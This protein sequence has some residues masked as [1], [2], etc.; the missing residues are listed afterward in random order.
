MLEL[1]RHLLWEYDL[2]TFDY[3]RNW[4]L[5]IERVIERGSMEE[6]RAAQA[7]YGKEKFIKVVDDSRQL[8]SRNKNFAR[9]FVDSTYHN[10]S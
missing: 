4:R 2:S 5:V 9:L 3:H 1:P 7:F 8:S 6:W 10:V